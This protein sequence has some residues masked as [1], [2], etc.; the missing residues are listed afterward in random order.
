M[1]SWLFSMTGQQ[2]YI[3]R[4]VGYRD[5]EVNLPTTV[6]ALVYFELDLLC[7]LPYISRLIGQ[8]LRSPYIKVKIYCRF[9]PFGL[10]RSGTHRMNVL[11]EIKR[12]FED[13][14]KCINYSYHLYLHLPN[15]EIK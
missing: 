7:F 15:A 13:A 12:F 11:V 14:K 1:E 10:I 9:R 3:L 6:G 4:A 2:L 8:I 5:W